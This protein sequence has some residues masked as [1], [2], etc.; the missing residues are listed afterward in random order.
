MIQPGQH[1]LGRVGFLPR[2]NK[3][4]VDHQNRQAPLARGDQL[5]LGALAARVF[6]HQQVDGVI[7][8]QAGIALDGERPAIHHQ[9]VVG[10]GWRLIGR[11]D[12]AQQVMV[13]RLR[14]KGGHMHPPQRQHDAARRPG[15][16]GHGFLHA[17]DMVPD[18]ARTGHPGRTGERDMPDAR[19]TRGFDGVGAHRRG[20]GMGGIDQMRYPLF[21]QIV[22]QP[23]AAAKAAY[24]HRH[25]LSVGG[26][27]PASVAERGGYALG[28][29]QARQ[30]AGFGG[31]AQKKDIRHG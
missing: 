9:T 29:Q 26:L 28:R 17:R 3:G 14:G 2:G 27:R 7:L 22:R 5:G 16:S 21:A 20:E 25:G 11:I 4:A 13:L 30:R 23:R 15:Q 8:N 24:A 1:I 18:V 6:A 31:A 19:Q 10:Q 12:K